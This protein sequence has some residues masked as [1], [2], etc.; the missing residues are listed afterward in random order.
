[1]GFL[2]AIPCRPRTVFVAAGPF[3][4][5]LATGRAIF[6]H[7]SPFFERFHGLGLAKW[8][9]KSRQRGSPDPF[10]PTQTLAAVEWAVLGRFWAYFMKNTSWVSV[11][12]KRCGIALGRRPLNL[13]PKT[14]EAPPQEV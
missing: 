4:G 6:W 10:F 5:G 9:L 1:M 13:V 11:R 2:L 8:G 14:R 3:R 12:L 7:K